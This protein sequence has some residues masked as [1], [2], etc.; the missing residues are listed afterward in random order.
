M[1]RYLIQCF[2]L[3]VFQVRYLAKVWVSEIFAEWWSSRRS[4]IKMLKERGMLC[5]F[6]F[7]ALVSWSGRTMWKLAESDFH[8]SS[9]HKG[10]TAKFLLENSRMAM[11]V[12]CVEASLVRRVMGRLVFRFNV[13]MAVTVKIAILYDVTLCSLIKNFFQNLRT[14]CHCLRGFSRPKCHWFLPDSTVSHPRRQ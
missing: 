14:Y 8:S 4:N 7:L 10:K 6:L 3:S 11:C 9:S 1:F 12:L 5:L 13:V 2:Y